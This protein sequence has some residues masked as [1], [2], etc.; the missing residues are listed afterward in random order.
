M[1]TIIHATGPERLSPPTLLQ[2]QSCVLVVF[3]ASGDLARRKLI[4]ALYDMACV[5]CTHPQFEVLGLGRTPM[6]SEQ[7]R[8]HLREGAMASSD[9]HDFNPAQ[10][11]GFEKRLFYLQ[12]G[13]PLSCILSAAGG[14]LDQMQSQGSSPN[15]LFYVSTPASVAHPIIEGLGAAGLNQNG[16]GWSRIVLE[17][18][19]GHD[20][21][22]AFS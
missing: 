6:T 10:W 1:S 19:F 4:P 12:G 21:D 22:S 18:P 8:A 15:R 11:A 13:S 3:G 5:G 20:L 2:G 9:T 16:K 7:F 17:K 14:S